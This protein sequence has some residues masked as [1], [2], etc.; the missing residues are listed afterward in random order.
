MSAGKCV[1]HVGTGLW[2][3]EMMA[4]KEATAQL[5]RLPQTTALQPLSSHIMGKALETKPFLGKIK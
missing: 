2:I 4:A 3:P 5:P 1:E